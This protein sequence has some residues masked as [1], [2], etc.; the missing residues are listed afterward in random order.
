MLINER[1]LGFI[2]V[3]KRMEAKIEIL[4]IREE[5]NEVI[6]D[7]KINKSILNGTTVSKDEIP[8]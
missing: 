2:K 6:G 4:N 3:L 1:R 8:I 7:I 5:N